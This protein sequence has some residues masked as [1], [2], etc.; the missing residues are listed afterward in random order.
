LIHIVM[1]VEAVG[2]M[3]GETMASQSLLMFREWSENP[4]EPGAPPATRVKLPV[5]TVHPEKSSS[6]P[7]V[8][9][10]GALS[11]SAV[12]LNERAPEGD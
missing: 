6:N 4:V 1:L 8:R 12:R 5:A 11:C 7:Y 9:G 2:T 10:P 3:T